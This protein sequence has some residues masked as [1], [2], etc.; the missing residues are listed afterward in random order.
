MAGLG[1]GVEAAS[2]LPGG[3]V[4]GRLGMGPRVSLAGPGGVN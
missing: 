2:H 4:S 3:G 1:S